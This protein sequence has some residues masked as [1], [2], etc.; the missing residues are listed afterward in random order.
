MA[1]ATGIDVQDL[2]GADQLCA[3][4][5]AG[6]EA[7]VLA[8]KSLFEAKDSECF[9]LVDTVNAFNTFS[10]PAALWNCRIL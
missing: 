10:R 7:A 3:G 6:I 4:A 2:C 8:M 5:K 1:L 9:L